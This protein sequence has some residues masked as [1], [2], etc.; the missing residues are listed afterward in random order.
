M[1]FA[2]T[3]ASFL[4]GTKT[5]TRRLG[6]WTDKNGKLSVALSTLALVSSSRNDP[7]SRFVV[8]RAGNWGGRDS[9]TALAAVPAAPAVTCTLRWTSCPIR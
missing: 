8:V 1:S 3:E 7:T 5:M 6:W 9:Q 2:L 4:D